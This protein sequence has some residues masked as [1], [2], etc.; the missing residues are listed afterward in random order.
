MKISASA[1]LLAFLAVALAFGCATKR[2]A[3][4]PA[5]Y[6]EAKS[7]LIIG[8]TTTEEVRARFGEP[9]QIT[10][11]NGVETWFYSPKPHGAGHN[12]ATG[13]ARTT[14]RWLVTHAAAAAL[15]AAGAGVF[16]SLGGALVSNAASPVTDAAVDGVA[17]GDGG[18]SP[19]IIVVRFNPEGVVE[20]FDYK[21]ADAVP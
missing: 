13:A 16:G 5:T 2:K 4:I 20:G 12:V 11:Q 19:P 9:R 7:S 6:D 21:N 8:Q 14:S 18:K 10:N 3:D 15:S 1:V 17:G